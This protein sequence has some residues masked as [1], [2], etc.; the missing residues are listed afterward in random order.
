M[1]VDRKVQSVAVVAEPAIQNHVPRR[2]E[3]VH[4]LLHGDR[5][6]KNECRIAVFE[7]IAGIRAADDDQGYGVQV[8]VEIVQEV[9]SACQ[10]AIDD[11]GVHFGPR[12]LGARPFWLRFNVHTDV[13]AAQNAFQYADF[14]PVTGNQQG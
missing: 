1:N 14:R 9:G 2:G 12:Q 13:E 5:L 4:G 6:L 10:I 7:A 8:V 11:Q 3:R